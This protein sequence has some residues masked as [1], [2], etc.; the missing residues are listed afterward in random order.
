M[1]KKLKKF[2]STIPF[3]FSK[4]TNNELHKSI[5][6]IEGPSAIGLVDLLRDREELPITFYVPLVY[7]S[8]FNK[9]RSKGQLYYSP[10]I[11]SLLLCITKGF[12]QFIKTYKQK[13]FKLCVELQLIS[14]CFRNSENIYSSVV[15][16]NERM[17]IAAYASE[18]ARSKRILSLCVQH[19]AV[20]EN[21]FPVMVDKYFVWDRWFG[22][23]IKS[24]GS[25]VEII[26]TG[27]LAKRPVIMNLTKS[28]A[29]LIILQPS[30]VSISE[31]I[32][33]P[34]F[35]EVIEEC[36][37]FYN[38]VHLRPHPNDNILSKILCHFPED[39]RIKIDKATLMNSLSSHHI[40]ISL[41]STVLL[42]AIYCGCIAI[43]YID[44]RWYKEIFYRTNLQANSKESLKKL[45]SSI[46]DEASSSI[47]NSESKKL[48][49]IF[50]TKLDVFL[51]NILID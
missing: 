23:V 34:N 2:A 36:L 6:I 24:S 1:L 5:I 51:S 17:P 33:I 37:N 20:V 3:F 21:Y 39:K 26:E 25:N 13:S 40:V 31:E 27:R 22:E 47:D 4:K 28:N 50:D 42:E 30:G 12:I 44:Q 14:N 45:L 29:P 18:W 7:F 38:E 32:I 46:E 9:V 35:V 8:I 49:S 48:S 15:I 16:F 19:G 10:G 11:T 41:Y 43:Q